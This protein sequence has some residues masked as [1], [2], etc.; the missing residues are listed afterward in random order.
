MVGQLECLGKINPRA[1][2]FLE[3]HKLVQ[4]LLGAHAFS[5]AYVSHLK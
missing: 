3:S 1:L 5:Q 4:L 2:A